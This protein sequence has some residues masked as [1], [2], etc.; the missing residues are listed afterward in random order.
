MFELGV[1]VRGEDMFPKEK[2]EQEVIK[3]KPH[4][5]EC[6]VDMFGGSN[7]DMFSKKREAPK[8]V[9][10][11]AAPVKKPHPNQGTTDM[12]GAEEIRA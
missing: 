2:I 1:G 12:F 9:E 11:A 3:K 5:N 8:V 4:P 7:E 6:S 10:T